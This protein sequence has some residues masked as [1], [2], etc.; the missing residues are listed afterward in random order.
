MKITSA[1][2]NEMYPVGTPVTYYPVLPEV[3]GILP[4]ITHTRTPAW[5]LGHGAPVV[6]V[7]GRAGGVYLTHIELREEDDEITPGSGAPVPVKRH[8]SEGWIPIDPCDCP[9]VQDEYYPH[10]SNPSCASGSGS[11][12][13]SGYMGTRLH[14]MQIC[15]LCI[16]EPT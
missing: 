8:G 6:S 14:H 4:L 13:C 3:P 10:G 2:F 11:S 9:F 5:D 12:F 16:E 7:E 1:Q 15:V